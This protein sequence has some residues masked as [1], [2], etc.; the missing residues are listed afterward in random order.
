MAIYRKLMQPK[1]MPALPETFITLLPS[2]KEIGIKEH[3]FI[4]CNHFY[5]A[6]S[7]KEL[8]VVYVV[9]SATFCPLNNPVKLLDMGV[10]RLPRQF[11]STA[12]I[13][14]WIFPIIVLVHSN[15]HTLSS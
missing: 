13:C 1:L 11:N 12:E 14:A 7:F 3:L 6:L 15:H 9:L 8:S 5:P 10:L 4:Y 2:L